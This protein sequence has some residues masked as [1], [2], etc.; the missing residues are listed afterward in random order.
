MRSAANYGAVHRNLDGELNVLIRSWIVARQEHL[1][2]QHRDFT[3]RAQ[4]MH[5]VEIKIR[6]FW[7]D[8]IIPDDLL[9][10]TRVRPVPNI[11]HR[12][13]KPLHILV[14]VNRE[15]GST[16]QPILM[17]SSEINE[18]GPS[19]V[20][21][22]TP[23]LVPPNIDLITVH[24]L[25]APPCAAQQ[26]LIPHPGRVR[27]WLGMG[28]NRPAT[29]GLF[30]PLW[31]DRRLQV[32][33]GDAYEEDDQ[34]ALLQTSSGE[35]DWYA[36]CKLLD[37]WYEATTLSTPQHLDREGEAQEDL[38]P[39]L[40]I[41]EWESLMELLAEPQESPSELTLIMHGLF[42]TDVGQ[43]ETRVER[44]IEDIR[45]A[46]LRTWEDY[47]H[48]GI[49][50]FLHI[51][52]PQDETGMNR[53]RT[54][55]EMSGAG[56]TFPARDVATLRRVHWQ[57][58][59]ESD[60]LQGAAYHTPGI[61]NF[62]LFAQTDLAHWC[63]SHHSYRCNVHIEN[64][65]LLPLSPANLR[66]GSRIDIFVH[67]QEYP[68]QDEVVSLMQQ[69]VPS[70]SPSMRQIRLHGLHCHLA[71]ILIDSDQPLV[72]AVAES[73]P[74]GQRSH[75]TVIALHPVEHPPAFQS[76]QDPM[77]LV[78][79]QEDYFEQVHTDDILALIT[80]SFESQS[81]KKQKIRTLWCPHKATRIDMLHFLRSVWY[82]RRPNLICFVYWN[83]SLWP[84][85]DNALRTLV[86]GDHV[87]LVIRSDGPE[88]CDIEFSE[89]TS[90]SYRVY[91][92]SSEPEAQAAPANPSP[93][94]ARSRSRDRVSTSR[95]HNDDSDSLIQL[96]DW[97][98]GLSLL[99]VSARSS[100]TAVHGGT[101][102]V[103]N[104][105]VSDRWCERQWT[106]D[107]S[108]APEPWAELEQGQHCTIRQQTW[109]FKQIISVFEIFDCNFTIPCLAFPDDWPWKG[110]ELQWKDLPFYDAAV[111][112]CQE[113]VVYS[114][115]SAGKDSAGAAA[116][117]FCRTN[118]GWTFG[119][120]IS[121]KLQQDT[122]FAAEQWG[123]IIAAKAIYDHLKIHEVYHGYNPSCTIL[124][125]SQ[126]AG[127]TATGQWGV[128]GDPH[129]QKIVRSICHLVFHRFGATI[130]GEHVAAHRGD[131][132]NEFADNL[133]EQARL[134]NT[135]GSGAEGI[136]HL[137]HTT[138]VK[139]WEWMWFLCKRD[140]NIHW[141]DD[142]LTVNYQMSQSGDPF[143]ILNLQHLKG[144]A[145]EQEPTQKLGIMDII[146]ATANVLT[147]KAGIKEDQTGLQ[148]TAR[149]QVVYKQ[150]HEQG[151]H[152]AAIQET[153]IRQKGKTLNP[154][155]IVRQAEANQQ[156]CFGVQL[157]FHKVLPIGHEVDKEDNQVFLHEEEIRYVARNPRY[158]IVKV[159]NPLLK[160]IVIAAHAPRRGAAEHE[161]AQFWQDITDAI[162][163][164]YADW[165]KIVL[166]DANAHLG[167]IP[168]DA[169]GIHQSE[170]EDDKSAHF[171]HFLVE[172]G[173][174]IPST[175]EETQAGDGGTWWNDKAKKWQRND[176][177][178][179]AR[180]WKGYSRASVNEDIDL[181]IC[182]DDH[183]VAQLRS[184]TCVQIHP[185]ARRESQRWDE[186]ALN[187]W[188]S[189]LT[190]TSIPQ[191][192]SWDLDV[193]SHAQ[194]LENTFAWHMQQNVERKSQK[195]RK[196]HLS[197]ET[198][199]CVLQKRTH[200]RF[201]AESNEHDRLTRLRIIFTSWNNQQNDP[202]DFT[203]LL[204]QLDFLVARALQRFQWSGREVTR[205]VRREDNEYYGNLAEE[206]GQCDRWE[207]L[208]KLWK[209][210]RGAL[211]KN[212]KR[213][214]NENP[215]SCVGLDDQ[216]HPYYHQ[217]E[218]G[219]AA[220][221]VQ[222][223]QDCLRRQNSRVAANPTLEALPSLCDIEDLLRKTTANRAPGLSDIPTAFYHHSASAIG[224]HVFELFLKIYVTGMEPL[225]WKGGI[226]TPIYKRGPWDQAA[227]YRAI[228][229]LP[230]LAKRFHAFLRLQLCQQI[231]PHRP[232]GVLGGFPHQEVHF[233]AQYLRTRNAIAESQHR[234]FGVL[235]IDIK[236]A[237]HNVIREQLA[238]VHDENL[239]ARLLDR[240]NMAEDVKAVLR[241]QESEGILHGLGVSEWLIGL[242][243]EVHHDTWYTMRHDGGL[244]K[245][246]RGTR[247][248]SPIADLCFHVL[249]IDMMKEVEDKL[250]DNIW[251]T[252]FA[253][254]DCEFLNVVWA[255]DV[256]I[257]CQ[258]QLP[259]H[260]PI[261][262]K[263]IAQLAGDTFRQR[264]FT[265]SFAKGKTSAVLALRGTG[266]P[267]V[268]SQ[269][270]LNQVAG[271]DL[272][273]QQAGNFLHFVPHYK[274]LGVQFVASNAA[275]L[276]IDMRIGQAK[277]AYCEM[278]KAVFGN[279]HVREAT[280]LKLMDSLI[281][282]RLS[283]GQ[284]AWPDPTHR[285]AARLR[286]CVNK[287]Y[288]DVTGHQYWEDTPQTTEEIYGKHH[289]LDIRVRLARDRLQYASRLYRFGPP[290]LLAALDE[291]AAVCKR[292]WIG[293]L[294]E[295]LRWIKTTIPHLI[296]T[297]LSQDSTRMEDWISWWRENPRAWKKLVLKAVKQHLKVRRWHRHIFK[298]VE[299][300]GIRWRPHPFEVLDPTMDTTFP[301][302]HCDRVFTT[303]QGRG[304]HLWK[305]HGRH[306]PEWKFVSG[307]TCPACQTHF[308]TTARLYQHLA[309][310][311][312]RE[313][314][315][316]C[317]A[318][319]QATGHQESVHERHYFST[320]YKGH[321]RV[322]SQKVAGPMNLLIT[323]D[324]RC[325]AA[326]EQEVEN[327]TVFMQ[328][329]GYCLELPEDFIKD[330][331]ICFTSHTQDWFHDFV[332]SG[333]DRE[334]RRELQ[335]RWTDN[336]E[337]YTPA[338]IDMWAIALLQ[339]GQEALWTTLQEWEDGEAEKIVEEEYYLLIKD[340]PPCRAIQHGEDLQSRLNKL[341]QR[342]NC[343]PPPIPHRQG[344]R[345]GRRH[346]GHPVLE[347]VGYYGN[348]RAWDQ[349]LRQVRHEGELEEKG[350]PLCRHPHGGEVFIIVHL[351][352]GR[353]RLG[354]FHSQ[355]ALLCK[356][357][358][359]FVKILSLDTAVSVDSGNLAEGSQSWKHIDRMFSKGM[360]AFTLAGSPCET[361]S[362]AR[363][364]APPPQEEGQETQRQW[365]RPLRS[366]AELWGLPGLKMKELRQV[367]VGS[368][369][370]LQT[371][372]LLIQTWK[373]GGA[374]VSEHP[375]I[376]SNPTRASTWT[377]PAM[378]AIRRLHGIKLN[379]IQQFRWG[380]ETVKPTALLH[381]RLPHF[382]QSMNKWQIPNV[383]YPEKVA[384]GKDASGRFN[385]A[386]AKEYPMALG[387]AFAQLAY[388]RLRLVYG[389][390]VGAIEMADDDTDFLAWYRAASQDSG[391]IRNG[392]YLPDYQPANN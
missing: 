238:G 100:R 14:E 47:F 375:A 247:P 358:P 221:G 78:E 41:D 249:M 104:P 88:W 163:K 390:N 71:T 161:I 136:W 28:Q 89:G 384:I 264:G 228:M 320:E 66:Q 198:W 321:T 107:P 156:G 316:K 297:D 116:V 27:R 170:E 64:R 34:L 340:L 302:Q 244:H 1:V 80:I 31:W 6:Q 62:E 268:R 284:C 168:T 365:P 26:M 7:P 5:E 291:E 325:L 220:E 217:L 190:P 335:D 133:A 84:E 122:S 83:G 22:W 380:A 377:S 314:V 193:H 280:R 205:R 96:S 204:K 273:G 382:W 218:A 137:A 73:W 162:P 254:I 79:H 263:R 266:A 359:F 52:K 157:L 305:A 196:T 57:E 209:R 53:L 366:A 159:A 60:Y 173:L 126:S 356:E 348:Q 260:L 258:T 229:L 328:T 276:E 195:R 19:N 132:G 155:Y 371:L 148:G 213:R 210:I 82:C 10:L 185:S 86:A 154:W 269:Y 118:W 63:L 287:M 286:A 354:D 289:L 61:N 376:P 303:P 146:F 349:Q 202:A 281:F 3:I 20:I 30:L 307:S 237:F 124:F 59:R 271:I 313:K 128:K 18:Q 169:V 317:Y 346:G 105:H 391:V 242:L 141:N 145:S 298:A 389:R 310:I 184:V 174:W 139:H 296:P 50:G 39:I 386:K 337:N 309:Y 93:S 219:E 103:A 322:E 369:L 211:P 318:I 48:T 274:H 102:E 265:L 2:L 70:Q 245:T 98:G 23:A 125:D 142:S 192:R 131:P 388:D 150:F 129:L 339:W 36:N 149:Q 147:L 306:A 283:F 4:L 239:F 182:K 363:H 152:V 25:C 230:S 355:L 38:A 362:E 175:F 54:I 58:E 257:P 186:A 345:H 171:H 81:Q 114:D 357:A 278:R 33:Q 338:T 243:A 121:L 385:T 90:R 226:L 197:E 99:Q 55:V 329:Q 212:K 111:T 76:G 46:V 69:V 158:L 29:A 95:Q 275:T 106:D 37:N 191:L 214:T 330:A 232:E 16:W 233:G 188:A 194:A 178:A 87:R 75:D 13:Q 176:Y 144:P 372:Y 295:D 334:K 108:T 353:R 241:L 206:A 248:G 151:I 113:M 201:L 97:H 187:Q 85:N 304:V 252:T 222:I 117:I 91:E 11:G 120:A 223:Q 332:D 236:N 140:P 319:L 367:Q 333:Y 24:A 49:T 12:G 35:K 336:W 294:Q 285:Q 300:T 262:I 200:R 45:A 77:Y 267:E 164:T 172:Q 277:Q 112:P 308:W 119:G 199:N 225:Q 165:D 326:L 341:R 324:Q 56:V 216:W 350:T 127:Y 293:G 40:I 368:V 215:L 253:T 183:R 279:R 143:E 290:T 208:Q 250:K 327:Y 189:S 259:V 123:T 378:E 44:N 231:A 251:L 381:T 282:S 261:A 115:G 207:G 65:I 240:I 166:A 370:H 361:F 351:F 292:S 342:V 235:F 347:A 17:A 392:T 256:A 181:S 343:P 153:R 224:Q 43:R 227:S 311:P 72:E 130:N 167:S 234:S 8:Y 177:V 387:G 160:A 179:I 301:C 68:E 110:P 364:Q 51:V 32:P 135:V 352:S 42:Q 373:G 272:D 331:Y 180:G 67:Q 270:L 15:D 312:R 379:H 360:V 109:S 101:Q 246:G 315:N 323:E 255:D 383:S 374:F 299:Q 203:S 92:S 94:T 288:R 74:Y 344:Q 138:S 21:R 9:T 134:G